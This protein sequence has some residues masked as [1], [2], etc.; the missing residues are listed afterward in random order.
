MSCLS[1]SIS[2]DASA[3][4]PVYGSSVL[5][6]MCVTLAVSCC[7]L[8]PFLAILVPSHQR[9]IN[10]FLVILSRVTVSTS[11]V[12]SAQS[13]FSR[14]VAFPKQPVDTEKVKSANLD[15]CRPT[16]GYERYGAVESLKCDM[17]CRH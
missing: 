17:C 2:G 6:D 16:W 14:H 13:S 3:P 5:G 9:P 12:D 8:E 11:H 15:L 7:L 1:F 10:F 4:Q